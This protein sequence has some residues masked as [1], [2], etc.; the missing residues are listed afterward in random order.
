MKTHQDTHFVRTEATAFDLIN[1]LLM[2]H[3]V[4]DITMVMVDLFSEL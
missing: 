4:S 1:N 2:F 3:V